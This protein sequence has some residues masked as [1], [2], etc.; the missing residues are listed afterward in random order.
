MSLPR[1]I[2]PE[3]ALRQYR[4]RLEVAGYGALLLLTVLA[5]RLFWLQVI[6]YDHYQAQAESNRIALLPAPPT[7][8]SIYDRSGNVL[9]QNYTAFTLELRPDRVGDLEAVLAELSRIVEITA[10]DLRRFRR[11]LAESRPFEWVTLRARLSDEEVARFA[12]HRY[13]FPGV[14]VR[15][16]QFR[17]YP[18]GEVMAHVVG[19]IGRISPQDRERLEEEGRLANYRGTDY[20]GKAGVEASY[21]HWLHGRTGVEKV[22]TDA[23]GRAVRVLS[24]TAPV[25]GHGIHL[26]L[27][28]G[29]QQLAVEVF[30]DYRG[31]L[32]ALDPSNGGVLTLVSRPG[33]DPNLFLDSID[34]ETW[35]ALNDPTERPLINRALRG[36]YPPGST[37]KPFMA[38]AG[39]ELGLLT[40]SDGIQDPG[41]FSLPG[42][43][44][45]FRDWKR[46]G[47][48]VVDLKRSVALSCDTYYYRLA[49][50]MGIDNMHRFLTRFG[51]GHRTGIDLG[52][53]LPGL[54]PNPE[55]KR[56]RFN[57]PWWPGETVIAGIGQGYML[58]TPL[59][60]A[61]A[62]MALAND[63]VIYA[64]QLLR[65]WQDPDTG[66]MHY[67]AP[68]I[69][70]RIPLK[71]GNLQVVKEAMVAVTQP[72]GTAARA[73]EGAPYAFAGKTGTAQ[74]IGIK[75]GAR[76]DERR[77]AAH[78]RDHAL[79]IAFAPA[80]APRIAVAVMVE[81]G[82]SGSLTAAPMARKIIDYWLTGKR[83]AQATPAAADQTPVGGEEEERED[84]L[85]A[86]DTTGAPSLPPEQ[87]HGG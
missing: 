15:A 18:Y 41:Y 7:R 71:P 43:S 2:A 53:E 20:I 67:A 54:V 25:A 46:D 8:G 1:Y 85:P 32:V 14:E 11:R 5:V 70:G 74:V 4:R 19:Y 24:R 42:S 87:A 73:G 13:R 30:G 65:A 69:L 27:D 12:V 51:F 72:G 52:G 45:R 17:Q 59:Q 62:A 28:A 22:E 82:G 64:P 36:V 77:I 21:E 16:R 79:F 6:H 81:N 48:G 68:R 37:I 78:H 9:A 84:S 76:Y 75:Q 86:L 26:H 40:P 56:R 50:Q 39:L 47:H 38:L 60:L 34:P 61:V 10:P 44:H 29:L 58:A 33:F 63:G 49:H 55:W 80:E 57:Q 35:A 31:A 3:E 83:P 66:R 23:G